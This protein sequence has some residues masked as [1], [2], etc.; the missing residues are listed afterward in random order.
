MAGGDALDTSGTL[1]FV[2][3][4]APAAGSAVGSATVGFVPLALSS[5]YR[6]LMPDTTFLAYDYVTYPQPSVGACQAAC[7]ADA[8]CQCWS[9]KLATGN[10]TKRSDVGGVFHV[11]IADPGVTSGVKAP[12]KLLGA[13][14]SP[15]ALSSA[16]TTLDVN[17]YVDHVVSEAFFQGGRVAMTQETTATNGTAAAVYSSA[18]GALQAARGW[19]VGS[20]WITPEEVLRTPRMDGKM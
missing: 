16:D 3:Y 1:F 2:S 19:R 6:R 15:L 10:C 14:S 5:Q 8:H 9:Y 12:G 13:T 7:D 11:P 4:A 18:D 17:V 20:I